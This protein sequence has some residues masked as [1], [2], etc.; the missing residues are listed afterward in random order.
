MALEAYAIRKDDVPKKATRHERT[1][2]HDTESGEI[3]VPAGDKET[4]C[5]AYDGVKVVTNDDGRFLPIS[6]FLSE[7]PDKA[8]AIKKAEQNMREGCDQVTQ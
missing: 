2:I 3:Y 6:W 1:F 5:A 7:Y 8:D 4:L